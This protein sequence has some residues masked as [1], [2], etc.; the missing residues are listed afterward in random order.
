MASVGP[1][2]SRRSGE[3]HL[4]LDRAGNLFVAGTEDDTIR[5]V[6]AS[7]VVSVFAS[8]TNLGSPY[9]LAFD[10]AGNLFVGGF[11][12][13]GTVNRI[14]QL[15]CSGSPAETAATDQQSRPNTRAGFMNHLRK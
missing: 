1:D 5:K 4:T 12:W 6:T 14:V 10:V 13:G 15:N 3:A 7:G 9:G 11:G 8:G 2:C